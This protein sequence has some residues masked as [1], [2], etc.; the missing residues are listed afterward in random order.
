MLVGLEDR[1]NMNGTWNQSA[2]DKWYQENIASGV[3]KSKL[4]AIVQQQQADYLVRQGVPSSEISTDP[5]KLRG[6][7]QEV[8]AG[9]YK[10]VLS[11]EKE[12][13]ELKME[14]LSISLDTL[15]K[16]LEQVEIR[17]PVA[18]RLLFLSQL[19]GG[20]I[21]PEAADY[22]ALRKGMIG[23]VA[24]AISGE[25]GVLTDRDIARAEQLLPK[26]S[27]AKGL[28]KRKLDNLRELIAKRSEGKEVTIP[29]AG[30]GEVLPPETTQAAASPTLQNI[31]GAG[32]LAAGVAPFLT[33]LP[34]GIRGAAGATM[35]T[36]L[37]GMAEGREL[38]PLQ[39]ILTSGGGIPMPVTGAEAKGAGIGALADILL[40]GAGKAISSLRPSKIA[41][42]RTALGEKIGEIDT[43][44]LK[45]AGENYVTK[46]NPT[47]KGLWK[48]I[49]STISDK[50]P[51]NEL[52]DKLTDWGHL[53]YTTTGD[54]RA[55]AEAGLMNK[56]YSSGR[57]ILK[58]QAPEIAKK[59]GQLRF[60]RE[61]PK[62]IQRGSWLALKGTAL[63][64]LLFGGL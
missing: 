34:P 40:T 45:A 3:S 64:R 23:P 63:G 57:Q 53:T 59:T 37:G 42:E 49:K 10:P 46:I 56:L 33:P 44:S 36:R 39:K 15:E 41:T 55:K 4:D 7:V 27:D 14:T 5:I 2:V 61:L 22:E 26:V 62:T 6:Q 54:V 13:A 8:S 16:N 9:K 12:K 1:G 31:L 38:S 48:E 58:E 43:K 51:A 50:M 28:A 60:L 32:Q 21:N 19:T 25:V 24:R 20:A 18:G 52:L 11:A 29:K 47:A 30:E 17:G 35:A